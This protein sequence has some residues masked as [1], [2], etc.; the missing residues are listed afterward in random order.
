MLVLCETEQ[1][2]VISLFQITCI[3]LSYTYVFYLYHI[4]DLECEDLIKH[5]LVVDADKRYTLKQIACHRW[6]HIGCE[7]ERTAYESILH[8]I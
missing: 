3:V 8:H 5:M 2:E 6:M 7:S 1:F 4:I